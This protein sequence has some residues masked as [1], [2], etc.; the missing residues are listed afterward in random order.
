MDEGFARVHNDDGSVT[1]AAT[2][3]AA[4]TLRADP[5]ILMAL[6]EGMRDS[7]TAI[8]GRPSRAPLPVRLYRKLRVLVKLA[9]YVFIVVLV[10]RILFW[11]ASTAWGLF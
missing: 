4:E 2:F 11:V 7:I 10:L 6:E 5:G 3:D 8:T 9:A 1:F